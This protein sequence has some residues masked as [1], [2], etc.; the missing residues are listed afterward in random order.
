M[1]ANSEL[2]LIWPPICAAV[3][4]MDIDT[5]TFSFSA[6]SFT[7]SFKVTGC[8][9]TIVSLFTAALTSE[10]N[11]KKHKLLLLDMAK[12][13]W[14]PAQHKTPDK[15]HVLFMAVMHTERS[16]MVNKITIGKYSTDK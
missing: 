16:K 14:S 10:K 1:Q 3:S 12:W 2:C 6:L 15:A 13:L 11:N 8:K 4:F 5:L 7:A 9:T